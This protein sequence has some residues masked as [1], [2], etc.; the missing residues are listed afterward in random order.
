MEP[1]PNSYDFVI[2]GSGGGSMCAALYLRSRGK[3]VLILEKMDIVGGTT[4]RSGGILWIPNNPFMARDGIPDSPEQALAYLESVTGNQSE[5]PAATKERR[6]M[7]VEEGPGMLAYLI[8]QGIELD[9]AAYWPDYYDEAP[10]G[11]APGRTVRAKLFDTRELGEWQDK[12]YAGF[13]DLPAY[14]DEMQMLGYYRTSWKSRR[15]MLRVVLRSIMAKLTGKRLVT[16][17]AALQGRM[18]QAALRAGVDIRTGSPVSELLVEDGAITGVA[19]T[20][21]G[22]PCR[23]KAALGVLVNAGG[24]SLNQR[25]RD[26]YIPGTTVDWSNAA[27]GNTGE[28]IEEMMR[29]G[30]AV[31]HMGE[32]VGFQCT[33]QP[34]WENDTVK[35]PAQRITAGPHAILVDQSGV[36]YMNEGGSYMAYCKGML[37]RNKTVPAVP[38]WAVFDQQFMDKYMIAGTM[39]GSRK[40]Q[41]WYDDG[42]LKRADSIEALAQ[43]LGIE[44]AVLSSTVRRFNG[45]VDNNCDE[46]FNRGA[47]AY[48][49]YLGDPAHK[50]SETLGRIETGPF[51]AVNVYPGD[52]G[53]YGGVVTDQYARVLRDDGAPIPG[54][55]ATGICAAS[56]NGAFYPGAGLSIGPTFTFGYVAAKHALGEYAVSR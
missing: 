56:M 28:M 9:R 18:L 22:K 48:D 51:Y 39:P 5:S 20:L 11:S 50:P 4:G 37:E 40:P 29:H 49:R 45:F 55:Y 14:M 16:A 26:Q 35:S 17:G 24:F 13:T 34:G 6:E 54:L 42:Y 52:V 27:P 36:R 41:S 19:A 43:Q 15:I 23:I 21:D 44:P 12:L 33:L 10:G 31:A 2:V 25:M 38:S 3:R 7:F 46:D 8:S 53:T 32:M 30:A 47:R 1:I